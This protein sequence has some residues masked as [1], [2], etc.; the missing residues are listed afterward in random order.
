MTIFVIKTV[1][2]LQKQFNRITAK[3]SS[4]QLISQ[5]LQKIHFT[6]TQTAHGFFS[7]LIS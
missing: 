5:L 7:D 6:E 1:M 4:L 2:L 3:A